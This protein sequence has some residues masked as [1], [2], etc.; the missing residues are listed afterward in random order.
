V[1]VDLVEGVEVGGGVC[2]AGFVMFCGRWSVPGLS[3]FCRP[4]GAAG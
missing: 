2:A 4:L 1:L 3:G